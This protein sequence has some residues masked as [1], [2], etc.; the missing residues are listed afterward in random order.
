MPAGWIQP[1]L[2]PSSRR[3]GGSSSRAM[4]VMIFAARA[5]VTGQVHRCVRCWARPRRSPRLIADMR[6]SHRSVYKGGRVTIRRAQ[7]RT[8]V[9]HADDHNVQAMDAV[10]VPDAGCSDAPS[11]GDGSGRDKPVVRP[12]VCPCYG[13]PCPKMAAIAMST[14]PAKLAAV[15]SERWSAPCGHAT[16]RSLLPNGDLLY[17][18]NEISSTCQR[19]LPAMTRVVIQLVPGAIFGSVVTGG[20]SA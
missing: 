19:H 18:W 20:M 2:A 11:S 5:G 6:L 8:S 10:E 7:R 9:R 14:S 17:R 4:S 12:H 15:S 16:G 1:P 13:Q 3:S